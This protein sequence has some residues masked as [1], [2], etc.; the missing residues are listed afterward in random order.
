[1]ASAAAENH[2]GTSIAGLPRSKPIWHLFT[3]VRPSSAIFDIHIALVGRGWPKRLNLIWGIRNIGVPLWPL[4]AN[5]GGSGSGSSVTPPTEVFV[6]RAV[7]RGLL[8]TP[9]ALER[10][11]IHP[12]QTCWHTHTH[13]PQKV[14]RSA[15]NRPETSPNPSPTR[16]QF[17]PK[18]TCD[19]AQIVPE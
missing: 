19:R 16:P 9:S 7:K 15:A 5:R 17:G 3:Q 12:S 13:N 8:T 10:L 4:A 1:M 14:S 2:T 18:P 6:K 11:D